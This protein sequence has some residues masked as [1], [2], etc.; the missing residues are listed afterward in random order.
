MNW[1][2]ELAERGLLPDFIV[3]S[4]IRGLLRGR[5]RKADRDTAGLVRAMR[6]SPLAL[7]TELA[8]VQH[9]EVPAEFFR[10]VLGPRL[11]YSCCLYERGVEDLAAAEEAMLQ[12]TCKRAGIADGMEVLDLGSGWGSVSLWIAEKYKGCKITA[13]S[14]SA[15]QKEFIEAE[16]GKLGLAGIDVVTADMNDFDTERR[17]DRIVSVEMFEHMRNYALLLER[18][19]SWLLPR[20]KTFVHIFCHRDIAYFFELDGDDDWMARHFFTGGLMPSFDLLSRFPEH[21]V[22][23]ERWKVS[24]MHYARTLRAWLDMFDARSDQ[25][26]VLFREVYGRSQAKRWMRKWRMFFMA[27]EELF[28]YRGGAEWMVGHYLLERSK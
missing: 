14:Y 8:N 25:V 5:L 26:L 17:F 2:A 23:V 24:G 21:M 18:V 28:A 22:V 15:S 19:S 20:G 6:R 7:A 4:G 13:V 11:K 3:R 1:K 16:A 9:Y 27:C 10:L 12:L